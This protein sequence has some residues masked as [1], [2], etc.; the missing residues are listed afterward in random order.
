MF[1]LSLSKQTGALYHK[2]REVTLGRNGKT[3][4]E[5]KRR[6]MCVRVSECEGSL[7][8]QLGCDGG[9]VGRDAGLYFCKETL[10]VPGG[11]ARRLHTLCCCSLQRLHA[12]LCGDLLQFLHLRHTIHTNRTGH[13][14]K[15]EAQLVRDTDD[16]THQRQTGTQ[17]TSQTYAKANEGEIKAGSATMTGQRRA[18]HHASVCLTHKH[19]H[20]LSGHDRGRA[21]KGRA[22]FSGQRWE[23]SEC[24]PDPPA[25]WPNIRAQYESINEHTSATEEEAAS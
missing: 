20:I 5:S 22:K 9:P 10:G 7:L 18:P 12:L 3:T 19:G 11:G 17:T 6:R 2:S 8:P 1:T 4:Q 23:N 25:S 13:K 24:T 16:N 21:K 15:K 14:H